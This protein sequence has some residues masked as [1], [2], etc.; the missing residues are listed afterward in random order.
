VLNNKSTNKYKAA[1]NVFEFELISTKGDKIEKIVFN[2]PLTVEIK[3]N[4]TPNMNTKK[5]GVYYFNPE[6]K[7]L[8]YV[9]GKVVEEGTIV[10]QAEHFSKYTVMEYDRVFTDMSDHWAKKEVEILAAR[11][12]I[13]GMDEKNY[14]PSNNVT[15]AQFAKLLVEALGLTHGEEKVTFTDVEA[16]LWYS[17]PI[18]IA[19]SL[20]IVQGF[21]GKFNPK[22]EIT[23]EEMSIMIVRALKV[24]DPTGDYEANTSSFADNDKIS[25]WATESVAIAT[26]RGLVSGM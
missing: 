1:S 21:D 25:S 17:E 12:I 5:L 11:H 6:S 24:V 3:Y 8:E 18:E 14:A 4:H 26:D 13:D 16:D 15:R 9:G 10:F 7:E 2:K 23:R 19:A 20:G 22:G